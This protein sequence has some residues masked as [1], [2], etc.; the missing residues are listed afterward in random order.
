[1]QAKYR[2]LDIEA[3]VLVA[4]SQ[5]ASA[6]KAEVRNLKEKIAQ[7]TESVIALG[8]R[9]K[10]LANSLRTRNKCCWDAV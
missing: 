1:M 9:G 5:I 4:I 8:T 2:N 3:A 6:L 10:K 7:M